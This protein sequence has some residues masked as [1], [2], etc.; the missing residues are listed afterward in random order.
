MK[1]S[2]VRSRGKCDPGG[3]IAIEVIVWLWPS[4][5]CGF[6]RQ[7]STHGLT[8][9]SPHHTR[10]F[11]LGEKI[12][13]FDRLCVAFQESATSLPESGHPI[14]RPTG[15][16]F[17]VRWKCH[18]FDLWASPKIVSVAKVELLT[19]C[20]HISDYSYCR[21]DSM[22]CN[23]K[24]KERYGSAC[25]RYPSHWALLLSIQQ[26]SINPAIDHHRSSFLEV[27]FAPNYLGWHQA[28]LWKYPLTVVKLVT[29]FGF[30][31]YCLLHNEFG[32][33][34]CLG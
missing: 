14:V 11:P 23:R 22:I 31:S 2:T 20:N 6:T 9:P 5:V 30:L 13:I 8:S 33:S 25:K 17:T 32:T 34:L 3:E 19:D 28:P 7:A 18:W 21:V 26:K 12:N 15:K 1:I 16:P 24:I 4:I 10:I 27:S 29:H